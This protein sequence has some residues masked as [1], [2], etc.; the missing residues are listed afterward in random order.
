MNKRNYS[1]EMD[2][3]LSHDGE[4]DKCLL[5]HAC[6]APCS[7]ASLER[8]SDRIHI[9]VFF[10]NP[11][12]VDSEEYDKRL[13]ELVRLTEMMHNDY[14]KA[15]IEVIAGRKEP[16]R[17]LEIAKGLEKEPEGGKRCEK[18]FRLR[19]REAALE[20]KRV[21]AD[22]FT[23]TL[24]I[25]PLKDADLL[26]RIGEEIG[27]EVGIKFLPSDF[28][29]KEGYKRSIEL[30]GKYGL[31]RQNYCGCPFSK[32]ETELKRKQKNEENT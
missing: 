31:Y 1:I 11:N 3:I 8:L 19:L 2:E 13:K 17:F 14:P 15:S 6:C 28:K 5:L 7:S 30:S 29:K 20:A 18:C 23:T 21:G 16:E 32:A 26:N 9:K 24:T 27:A 22:Y 25:S 4:K 10:Y 12:I